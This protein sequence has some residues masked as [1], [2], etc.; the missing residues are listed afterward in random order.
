MPLNILILLINTNVI[1]LEYCRIASIIYSFCSSHSS[2]DSLVQFHVERN[3]KWP[4]LFITGSV[5][6]KP[7]TKHTVNITFDLL[8]CP[9]QSIYVKIILCPVNNRNGSLLRSD[10]VIVSFCMSRYMNR[11]RM[12]PYMLLYIFL[13]I[14]R[15]ILKIFW[16][17]PESKPVANSF[18]QLYPGFKITILPALSRI[19]P[20]R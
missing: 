6:L 17:H 1:N 20:C 8:W 9:L 14:E 15:P 13:T 16:Q 5:I 4:G 7:E 11:I 19:H 2:T 12:T 10:T 3:I 18:R